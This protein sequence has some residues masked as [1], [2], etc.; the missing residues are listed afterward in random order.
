MTSKEKTR[1]RQTKAWKDFRTQLLKTRGMRCELLGTPVTKKTAQVHHLR[2]D[3][4]DNLD[5]ALFQILSPTAHE[6][7]EFVALVLGGK[8]VVPNRAVLLAW[9]GPFLPA[10]ERTVD[11]YYKMMLDDTSHTV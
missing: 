1:F 7:V 9:L 2:P 10:S 4:Y 8:T 3:Q 5:P 11:K 6:F